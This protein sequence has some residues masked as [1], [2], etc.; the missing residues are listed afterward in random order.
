MFKE[1]KEGQTHYFNDG[2]GEPEHNG[3]THCNDCLAWFKGNH[4]CDGLMKALVNHKKSTPPHTSTVEDW[5]KEFDEKFGKDG[6][7]KNSDSIG[8]SAGCDDCCSNI[9]LRAE[10]KDFI[11]QNFVSKE[12]V[13]EVAERTKIDCT[14][15]ECRYQSPR[16]EEEYG[17]FDIKFGLGYNQCLEDIKKELL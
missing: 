10:H 9:E 1:N 13:A 7:D 16:H 6:P 2:C 4:A 5:E 8:R 3:F 11:R 14:G 15:K 12:K 17:I